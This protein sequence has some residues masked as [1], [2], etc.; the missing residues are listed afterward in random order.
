[1]N[2]IKEQ[3]VE[4]WEIGG[5]ESKALR[6]AVLK[7]SVGRVMNEYKLLANASYTYRKFE[8]AKKFSALKRSV[9]LTV[10]E[11]ETRANLAVEKEVEQ[12]MINSYIAG[13]FETTYKDIE[14]LITTIQTRVRFLRQEM[15]SDKFNAD[16]DGEGN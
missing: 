13:Y 16:I 15:I 1:M 14:Q 8:S 11:A 10:K 9:Q 7:F 5:M 3:P 4:D 2:E 12:E 6:L